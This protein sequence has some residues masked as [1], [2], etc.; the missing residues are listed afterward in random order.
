[1]ATALYPGG[2]KPPHRGHFEVVKKL[3]SGTHNG[4]VYNFDNR[5]KIGK[6]ALKGKSDKVDKIDKVVVFIGAKDRNGISN[7]MSKSIWNIYKKYLGNVEIYHEVP[8]PMANASAYAK[9]RPNE[10][11]YA[12][13][14]I[15]GEEDVV[16]L[17][18]ITTFKNRENVE[19]LVFAAPGG[20]RAT[21]LRQAILSGNLDRIRDFFPEELKR[22]EILDIVNMIK[23]SIISEIMAEKVDELFDE[24]FQKEPIN[25]YKPSTPTSYDAA[26]SSKDRAYLVT[27]Y[28]R[29]KSQIG[30][31]G[32][33]IKFN[34]DHIR[35][36]LDKEG[37]S[38]FDYTPYMASLLEYMLNEGMKITPLPEIKIRRDVSESNNFFGR[39][40]YYDPNIK[41]I[42]LYVEGR[43]PKDIM[44]SFTHEMVHHMQNLENRLGNIQTSNTNE[45]E[46][47]LELEKEAYLTGNITFRNWEDSVKNMEEGLW[48]NINAKKKAGKKSSHKN[49][50]AYKAAKKAGQALT[51]SKKAKSE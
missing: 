22:E 32:V 18:R 9:E 42:V 49:S 48:A 45:S 16:D 4:K 34:Q 39:T 28:N 51:R 20:T 19:G 5:E 33:S 41:E 46:A 6:Q 14:G 30:T 31:S 11:F 40:A 37:N 25:E 44:R 29:I 27:L 3:L 2:F 50:K 23:Q 26:I 15:R 21:D 10:K 38:K 8:N 35:V 36:G 7:E 13:T 1:M 43:H 17:R 47:L 12:V 24:W